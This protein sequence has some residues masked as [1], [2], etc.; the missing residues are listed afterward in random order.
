MVAYL[1][2]WT[3]SDSVS[4]PIDNRHP[5]YWQRAERVYFCLAGIQ[6]HYADHLPLQY[7]E[8]YSSRERA[9]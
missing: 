7:D 9:S 5:R 1:W 8:K 3:E 2:T 4:I 6:R